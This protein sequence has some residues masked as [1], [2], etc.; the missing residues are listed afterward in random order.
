MEPLLQKAGK[1]WIMALAG[2][3]TRANLNATSFMHEHGGLNRLV[4]IPYVGLQRKDIWSLVSCTLDARL[5]HSILP[6]LGNMLT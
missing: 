2:A 3:E 6:R 1:K 5:R 4:E